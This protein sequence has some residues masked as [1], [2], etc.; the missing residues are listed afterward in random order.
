LKEGGRHEQPH[1]AATPHAAVWPFGDRMKDWHRRHAIQIAASLPDGAEDALI[2][3]ELA[4]QLVA[5]FLQVDMPEPA[6]APVVMLRVV[7]DERVNARQPAGA[8]S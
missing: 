3:L 4:R 1:Q 5:T 7:P 8:L 6:K 2:V